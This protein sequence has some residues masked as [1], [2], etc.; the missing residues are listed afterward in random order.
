M[1]FV[2]TGGLAAAVN[3]GSRIGLSHLM[4]YEWAVAH[5][6]PAELR[7]LLDC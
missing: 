2:T 6:Y 5:L 1:R 7:W 3:I 4:R